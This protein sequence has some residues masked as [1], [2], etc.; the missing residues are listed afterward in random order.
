MSYRGS[1][2]SSYGSQGRSSSKHSYSKKRLKIN[3]PTSRYMEHV[4]EAP[5][6]ASFV[7]RLGNAISDPKVKLVLGKG[8]S[9][10]VKADDIVRSKEVL[11]PC[12]SLKPIQKEIDLEKSL[13]F[14]G[15]HPENVALYLKGDTITSKQFGGNQIVTSKG[16]FIVDGHHRWSQV[17]MINPDAKVESID[18]N[19]A[20]PENALVASQAAIA[21]IT[22]DVSERK[23][24]EGKN[25][26]D[27][28]VDAIRKNMVTYF[29]PDFYEAFYKAKPQ[30]FKS[31]NDVND[32]ILGNI[33]RMRIEAKPATTISRSSMP[34]FDD[35]DVHNAVGRLKKGEINLK[36]P[37]IKSG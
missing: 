9:D 18:L 13:S 35:A 20:N 33:L 12:R 10:G 21:S 8:L 15:K 36:K 31:K 29:T 2:K 16:K 37:F 30:H 34:V 6:Y 3:G 28:P 1:K 24:G 25:I 22:G 4:F 7:N 11:K 32:Y 23:V 26:Y 5:D 17:Y 27:M 19:V 14:L